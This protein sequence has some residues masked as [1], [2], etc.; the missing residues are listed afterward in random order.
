MVCVAFVGSVLAFKD[1]APGSVCLSGV[2]KHKVDPQPLS[3]NPYKVDVQKEGAN[4]AGR[5]VFIS[6]GLHA[7]EGICVKPLSYSFNARQPLS[8]LISFPEDNGFNQ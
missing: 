7:P 4:Y 3:T 5:H 8:Y 6:I 1:G 2:P